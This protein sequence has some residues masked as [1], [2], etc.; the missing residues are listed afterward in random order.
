MTAQ[1]Q[2]IH[3][4]RDKRKPTHTLLHSEQIEKIIKDLRII[5]Q[6]GVL[7]Q[8]NADGGSALN[9]EKAKIKEISSSNHAKR[10]EIKMPIG[11]SSDIQTLTGELRYVKEVEAW[12]VHRL[13]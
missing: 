12:R 4:S 11:D 13:E 6:K 2:T 1:R 5:E 8:P 9:W 3:V 10:F 7:A